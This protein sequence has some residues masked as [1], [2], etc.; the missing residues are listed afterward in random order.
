MSHAEIAQRLG[1]SEVAVRKTLS[2]G[3]AR[4]IAILAEDQEDG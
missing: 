2:R 4:L 3:L 1:K